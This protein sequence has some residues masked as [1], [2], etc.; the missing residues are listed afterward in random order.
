MPV[1][2]Q[3][4]RDELG[5]DFWRELLGDLATSLD[6]RLAAIR[7]APDHEAMTNAAHSLKGAALGLDLAALAAASG[8]VERLGREGADAGAA[9][10]ALSMVAGRT[11][12]E[13][14]SVLVHQPG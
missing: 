4:I 1:P 11:R 5:A 12:R 9:I 13:L 10:A 14:E 8:A 7:E 3:R 2:A 6:Q